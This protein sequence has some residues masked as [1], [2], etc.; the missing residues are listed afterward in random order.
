MSK[1]L[2]FTG[3]MAVQHVYDASCVVAP[4]DT[5]GLRVRTSALTEFASMSNQLSMH[6]ADG[7]TL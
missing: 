5:H 7:S 6:G 4:R 2:D 3:E 1:Y